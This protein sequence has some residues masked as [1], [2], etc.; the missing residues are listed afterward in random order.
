MS[1]NA[2]VTVESVEA[3]R[4][5]PNIPKRRRCTAAI[6]VVVMVAARFIA[7][8]YH[9]PKGLMCRFCSLIAGVGRATFR[10]GGRAQDYDVRTYAT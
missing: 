9:V 10:R 5:T 8:C 6:A 3:Y 2:E 1:W 7:L 4:D